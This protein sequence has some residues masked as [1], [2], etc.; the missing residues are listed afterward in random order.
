MF[1]TLSQYIDP[2]NIPKKY[3]GNLEFEYGMM[4]ILEPAIEQALTWE[5]PE[6]QNGKN[7]WP[8]GPIKWEEG[9]DGTVKAVAVG[10]EG[11]KP[12]RRVVAKLATDINIKAMHGSLVTG[13]TP[14]DE[15][16]LALTTV[17]TATHP[18]DT[19]EADLYTGA[20]ASRGDA[21]AQETKPGVLE[22]AKG[23]VE[24]ATN[25][26]ENLVLSEKEKPARKSAEAE[27][28]KSE[29]EKKVDGAI[30]SEKPPVEGFLREQYSSKA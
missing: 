3:G 23:A 16:E 17:G 7:I 1:P 10:S 2:D 27:K 12:R 19:D 14:I 29:E 9:G 15:D 18:K 5:N 26:V 25:A 20:D 30:D 8:I 11:G 13:N 4:P 6:K 28:G 24:S 21:A 22:Q